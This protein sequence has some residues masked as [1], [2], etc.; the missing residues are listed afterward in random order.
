MPLSE[1]EQRL[2][3]QI[4]RSLAEDPKFASAVRATDP[5][6]HARRRIVIAAVLFLAG[7]ALLIYGAFSKVALVGVAGF[8][9]MLGSAVFAMQ[10]YR[11]GQNRDLRA[12]GGTATRRTRPRRSSLVDRLEERWRRRP[13]DNR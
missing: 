11:Q 12:V 4:E 6:F 13:E 10:S 3:E 5:R 8:V 9:V 2:F 7:I 1:H